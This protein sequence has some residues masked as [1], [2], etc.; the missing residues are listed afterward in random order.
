MLTTNAA[1]AK[2][3]RAN[4]IADPGARAKRYAGFISYSQRDKAMAKR[5]HRALER[6]SAPANGRY[7]KAR[8]LGRFFRDD[9][10]L[11][12]S[13]SLGTA[14][15]GA[16][17]DAEWLIVVCSPHAAHSRWVDAEV[18]R[19]KSRDGK[20]VFAV[21]V[22]GQPNSGSA[23]TECFCPA[24][25]YRVA[26]EGSLLDEPDE[27]LAPDLRTDGLAKL[28]TRVASG[29][30]D[31]PF[32]T[33]WQRSRRATR[34]RTLRNVGLALAGSVAVGVAMT[35]ILQARHMEQSEALIA[36]SREAL[37]SGYHGSALRLA[38]H[39]VRGWLFFDAPPEANS[40]LLAVAEANRL[41]MSFEDGAGAPAPPIS[42]LIVSPDDRFVVV[43]S[44]ARHSAFDGRR[45]DPTLTVW[46]FKSGARLASHRLID[47][48]G[49][50][51][52]RV[53]EPTIRTFGMLSTGSIAAVAMANGC[54]MTVELSSPER[55]E[56]RCTEQA[57]EAAAI[58]PHRDELVFTNS[59]G[60]G[61]GSVQGDWARRSL[62]LPQ[63]L[64][65][66]QP[67]VSGSL[68]A[69]SG[70]GTLGVYD[71]EV[72]RII[73]LEKDRE[74][75]TAMRISRDG[76]LAAFGLRDGSFA[77][78][79]LATGE[80]MAPIRMMQSDISDPNGETAAVALAFAPGGERLLVGSMDGRIR[81]WDLERMVL[82]EVLNSHEPPRS[83]RISP[84][85]RG[86]L[87]AITALDFSA[88]G[89]R[90]L[91]ASAHGGLRIWSANTLELIAELKAHEDRDQ[92]P[93]LD[94]GGASTAAFDGSGMFAVSAGEDGRLF[95]WDAMF[96]SWRQHRAWHL[97]LDDHDALVRHA[98]FSP[99]GSA[100]ALL[101]TRGELRIYRR[102]DLTSFESFT[103]AEG[104]LATLAWSPDGQVLALGDTDGEVALFSTREFAKVRDL[105]LPPELH[106]ASPLVTRIDAAES[107]ELARQMET[108][109]LSFGH[110]ADGPT[111][112]VGYKAESVRSVEFTATGK[113][114]VVGYYSGV[115]AIYD[116]ASGEVLTDFV[117]TTPA[118][119]WL[120]DVAV[121]PRTS[122]VAWGGALAGGVWHPVFA[123]PLYR[124]EDDASNASIGTLALSFDP[125]G[126][127]LA[128]A[129]TDATVRLW[130]ARTGESLRILRGHTGPVFELAFSADGKRLTTSALD[131]HARIWDVATG[132]ELLA[133]N[134]VH[135]GGG[136]DF[137]P[138]GR[139]ILNGTHEGEVRLWEVE[140]ISWRDNAELLDYVCDGFEA[141]YAFA[142]AQPTARKASLE[143]FDEPSVNDLRFYSGTSATTLSACLRL[144]PVH[145]LLTRS[146]EWLRAWRR[147]A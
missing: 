128:S 67:S 32:D 102:N 54:I 49:D 116:A 86:G 9:E 12:A 56:T 4:A 51:G 77:L 134:H 20:K 126:R 94:D 112:S 108:T 57:F 129:H 117:P 87:F 82:V 95:L 75:V 47:A 96:E 52:N 89:R 43:V 105:S 10:E 15:E 24:L 36:A 74:P 73:A 107:D 135:F 98:A 115:V 6:F 23:E 17:D 114:V 97:S 7:G 5:L 104:I 109:T 53:G 1:P 58:L 30:L 66:F 27:P 29:L 137:D 62:D 59:S 31:V 60:S 40:N 138:R 84:D 144:D 79:D 140:T 123:E 121:D 48:T 93:F 2:S 143:T 81:V 100:L 122:A 147:P 64:D 13:S 63:A 55:L 33:L 80:E 90:F 76:Q 139:W 19:F 21:I 38:A 14:L 35:P 16:L 25:R 101:D 119:P 120:F 83:V 26:P 142:A 113:Q 125:E 45:S 91:S 127:Y 110:L 133:L 28:T 99:D 72:D 41:V 44:P 78:V 145:R 34:M 42:E 106:R 88:D 118:A 141:D 39:A 132:Q 136:I 69:F 61:R 46:E 130:D 70:E 18:R 68:L 8:R 71:L 85:T 50:A 103:S 37:A 11:G 111:K 3:G 146:R 92:H 124:L 131:Y 65:A 22:D